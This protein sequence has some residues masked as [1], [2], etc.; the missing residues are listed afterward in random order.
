MK[1]LSLGKCS[2]HNKDITAAGRYNFVKPGRRC[3]FECSSNQGSEIQ[4]RRKLMCQCR[5]PEFWEKSRPCEWVL[6]KSQPRDATRKNGNFFLPLLF[7]KNGTQ[8]DQPRCIPDPKT[9]DDC[10][11]SQHLSLTG[12]G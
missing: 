6:S 2:R 7:D 10:D 3:G 12:F 11:E 4:T 1:L 9:A 5:A 8:D